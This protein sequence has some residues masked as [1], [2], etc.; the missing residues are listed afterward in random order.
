MTDTSLT[1]FRRGKDEAFRAGPHSPIPP[2]ARASFTTLSY[3]P[4]N[5]D[6]VFEVTVEPG[7][8]AAL[9][10]PTS[11]GQQRR[12]HRIGRVP[13][14]VEGEHVSLVLLGRQDEPRLFLAF[15]DATSGHETYGS[16]RYL[17]VEPLGH[18]R[19]RIDFNYAYNPFCAYSD[20]YSR[21]LPPE[22]N[23]LTVLI[24]AGEKHHP[25]Q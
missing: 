11:D 17:E 7:D 25:P 23:W 12:Y 22:E 2:G 5:P 13:L 16:G 3:F 24:R 9:D 10:I 15:G 6:L 19:V 8:G 18:G 1:A 4:P 21:P 14:V 20:A